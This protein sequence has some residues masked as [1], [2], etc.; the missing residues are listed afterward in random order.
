MRRAYIGF[1][2]AGQALLLATVADV[3]TE[4]HIFEDRK[5][6]PLK[7]SIMVFELQS[8]QA[9]GGGGAYYEQDGALNSGFKDL[10]HLL[11]R[12]LLAKN[13]PGKDYRTFNSLIAS[14]DTIANDQLNGKFPALLDEYQ[15]KNQLGA[16]LL[17][18]A[19]TGGTLDGSRACILRCTVSEI[20]FEIYRK[21]RAFIIQHVPEIDLQFHFQTRVLDAKY[22]EDGTFA[23][24]TQS[25]GSHGTTGSFEF[26]SVV[27]MTGTRTEDL[28]TEDVAKDAYVGSANAKHI[29]ANLLKNGVFNAN[30]TL[31]AGKHGLIVG[32][33]LHGIDMWG[34]DTTVIGANHWAP[35]APQPC[36]AN[37]D[38]AKTSG[39]TL[40][41][42]GRT[43]AGLPPPRLS[44][45]TVW[46]GKFPPMLT[47]SHAR[48]F[49]HLAY[50]DY[51]VFKEVSQAAMAFE[52]GCH[53]DQLPQPKTTD[54]QL[55][56]YM[57][58]I[59]AND[60]GKMTLTFMERQF[61]FGREFGQYP[62]ADPS[63]T[64]EQAEKIFPFTT[65]T[66]EEWYNAR[67]SW[68]TSAAYVSKQSN[69][70]TIEAEQWIY[71]VFAAP[72]ASSIRNMGEHHE[73]GFLKFTT[74]NS[75]HLTQKSQDGSF[76]LDGKAY[77][78]V[79]APPIIKSD[80]NGIIQSFS[81]VL[82]KDEY[83]QIVL[84]ANRQLQLS[85]GTP[86]P[87]FDFGNNTSGRR[88]QNG[89]IVGR[90]TRDVATLFANYC[91]KPVLSAHL[92]MIERF[93]ANGYP[94]PCISV[95]DLLSEAK[96]KEEH[97]QDAAKQA[98]KLGNEAVKIG[99]Y[100]RTIRCLDR[101]AW[102]KAYPQCVSEKKR[103]DQ[104]RELALAQDFYKWFDEGTGLV[105]K[106]C[107]EWW[108]QFA[109][110]PAIEVRAA[111]L[112]TLEEFSTQ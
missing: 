43:E 82:K 18:P 51:W 111:F 87:Y 5:V 92:C 2:P 54:D 69:A 101:S 91:N 96:P 33:V 36:T 60:Q 32:K 110:V 14:L 22:K 56:G 39:S 106:S 102:L 68:I 65:R 45:D 15:N 57:R 40:T 90:R 13:I 3:L 27:D 44:H 85:D 98:L 67:L 21:L 53:P 77:Q 4:R 25:V 49:Q 97:Y 8:E 28:V 30:G 79:L 83:G 71:T 93:K 109:D 70:E 11:D 78:Y 26:D 94:K 72:P 48:A 84:A 37:R 42:M 55:A 108:D 52:L 64:D 62:S 34:V 9:A 50:D 103:E 6:A 19:I 76:H 17:V 80:V 61:A 23:L 20:F 112:V 16:N 29:A 41:M 73:S 58:D 100:L 105:T 99:T 95:Q 86:I 38:F 63:Q 31:N 104:M 47:T 7:R 46:R 24:T 10:I 89:S 35:D 12:D 74:G 66:K 88:L 81:D 1:G 75:R 107:D 59:R